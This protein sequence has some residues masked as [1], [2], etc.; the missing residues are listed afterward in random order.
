MTII[1]KNVFSG[2]S[3]LTTVAI[4]SGVT[5]I[6]NGAFQYCTNLTSIT[7]PSGVTTIGDSAFM[8]CQ[9]LTDID[10]PSSVTS[11]G[12]WAFM[13]CSSLK[14]FIIPSGVT[15]IKGL[16]FWNCTSLTNVTIPAGVTAIENKA[17]EGCSNLN[18]V[19]S[20]IKEPFTIAYDVFDKSTYDN[21]KLFVPA[22]TIDAYNNT[23]SWSYFNNIQEMDPSGIAT[24]TIETD[25]TRYIYDLQGRQLQQPLHGIYIIKNQNGKTIKVAK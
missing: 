25:H 19:I 10:L 9:K 1:D 7:I 11:I 15:S 24:P 17:F 16:T 23:L 18:S 3:N 5:S 21:A 20:L 14:E 13:K 12:I 22:G 6:G 4:P 2:C 8:E